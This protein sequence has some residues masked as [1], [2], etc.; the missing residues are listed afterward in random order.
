MV[1]N[2]GR[3]DITLQAGGVALEGELVIPTTPIG[4]V[5]FANGSGGIR[6]NPR[7]RVVAEMLHAGHIGTLL[8]D[9]LTEAESQR[10]GMA[11]DTDLLAQRLLVA[12]DWL[13]AHPETAGLPVG[14]F[15]AD[16]GAAPAIVA[17]AERRGGVGAVVARGGRLEHAESRLHGVR[18]PTLLITGERDRDTAKLTRRAFGE[19]HCQKHLVLVA[20]A[21]HQFDEPGTLEDAAHHAMT[22]FSTHLHPAPVTV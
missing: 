5:V 19:L 21:S 14:L 15:G 4:V 1:M 8:F 9:L 2:P 13:S 17:A 12:L 22:W 6:F 3:T 16:T 18:C 7:N 20:G 11:L 10:P